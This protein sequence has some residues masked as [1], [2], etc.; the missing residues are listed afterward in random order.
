MLLWGEK[1]PW[2]TPAKAELIMTLKPEAVYTPVAAGRA[3]QPGPPRHRHSLRTLV[4]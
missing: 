1:D 3:G 2:M 4:C